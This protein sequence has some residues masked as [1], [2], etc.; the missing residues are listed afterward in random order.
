MTNWYLEEFDDRTEL[1]TASY[2]LH[3]MTVEVVKQILDVEDSDSDLPIDVGQNGV[4]ATVADLFAEYICEP[5]EVKAGHS[6]EVALL[7]D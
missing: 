5:F 6:Y 4:P 7:A 2:L 1:G 3:G